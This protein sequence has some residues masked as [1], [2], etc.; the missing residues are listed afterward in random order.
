MMS[1][2]ARQLLDDLLQLSAD[3]RA[4]IEPAL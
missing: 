3:D 1:A 2:R 4:L